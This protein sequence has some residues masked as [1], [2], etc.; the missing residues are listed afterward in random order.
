MPP[1]FFSPHNPH[2]LYLGTQFVLKT[3]DEGKSWQAISPDLTGWSKVDE[4]EHNPDR[5][6]PP[7]I[8]ALAASTLDAGVMWAGTTNRIVQLTRDGGGALAESNSARTRSAV[9]DSLRGAVAS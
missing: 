8:D 7:A 9:G 5:P 2:T 1:L 3:T 4:S 6:R